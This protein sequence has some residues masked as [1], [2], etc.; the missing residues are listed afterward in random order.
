MSHPQI[1]G[2]V[3]ELLITH[4]SFQFESSDVCKYS[5]ALLAFIIHTNDIVQGSVVPIM[6]ASI[7]GFSLVVV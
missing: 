6:F 4:I 2:G 5:I 1:I 7:A 3:K